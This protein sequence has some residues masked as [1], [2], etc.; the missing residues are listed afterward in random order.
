MMEPISADAK[1]CGSCRGLYYD[2]KRRNPDFDNVLSRIDGEVSYDDN[3]KVKQMNRFFSN[4]VLV[5]GLYD[6]FSIIRWIQVLMIHLVLCMQRI[7]A[8][9]QMPM[10]Y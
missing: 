9:T 8:M 5:V 7:Q 6:L 1:I 3:V 2:W 10:T 4:V